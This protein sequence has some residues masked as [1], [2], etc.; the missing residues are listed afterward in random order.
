M[1]EVQWRQS[2]TENAGSLSTSSCLAIILMLLLPTQLMIVLELMS[3]GDLKEYLRSILKKWVYYCVKHVVC[4]CGLTTM[5]FAMSL[6]SLC[7]LHWSRI[8]SPT[9]CVVNRRHFRGTFLTDYW[10]FVS[11]L[12][13]VWT[14]WPTRHL[15]TET[16]LQ[17]TSSWLMISYARWHNYPCGVHIVSEVLLVTTNLHVDV[18]VAVYERECICFVP[19][20]VRLVTLVWQGT[21]QMIVSITLKGARSPS[22]GQHQR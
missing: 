7:M 14:T 13:S 17:E 9:M 8:P 18:S 5:I 11:R 4:V 2:F 12:P 1:V 22:S 3:K 21:W 10:T 19:S 20:P 15:Y 16:W 6:L